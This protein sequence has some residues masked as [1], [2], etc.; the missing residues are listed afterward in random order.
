MKS[1]AYKAPINHE[2][3]PIHQLRFLGPAAKDDDDAALADEIREADE[4]L[5]ETAETLEITDT[6]EDVR[7]VDGC[8]GVLWGCCKA[9]MLRLTTDEPVSVIVTEDPWAFVVMT[10]RHG[11]VLVVESEINNSPVMVITVPLESLVTIRV[12]G[13][14]PDSVDPAVVAALLVDWTVVD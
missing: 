3:G 14:G 9:L 5:L 8:F 13:T 11:T 2:K 6:F 12:V 1:P 4:D 10:V 7:A